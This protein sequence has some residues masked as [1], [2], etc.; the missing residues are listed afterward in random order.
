RYLLSKRYQTPTQYICHV[1]TE[2][3][4]RL[5]PPL[6]KAIPPFPH[7]VP[8]L[9]N[10]RFNRFEVE[11][12]RIP[13]GPGSVS[14]IRVAAVHGFQ[15]PVFRFTTFVRHFARVA[16]Q[17]IAADIAAARK[18][19]DDPRIRPAGE[20]APCQAQHIVGGAAAG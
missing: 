11:R 19:P 18:T 9:R 13:T 3:D 7:P 20:P 16:W 15:T 2:R 6:R 14:R 4:T 12:A 10:R 8:A 1:L 5:P 17:R